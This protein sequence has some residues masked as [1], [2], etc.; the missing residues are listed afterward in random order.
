[1]N[2]YLNMETLRGTPRSH[3][4]G[5]GSAVSSAW[6]LRKKPFQDEQPH[7]LL[8]RDPEVLG[9]K[10]TWIGN[11]KASFWPCPEQC[12]PWGWA[13]ETLRGASGCDN[14]GAVTI[15]DQKNGWGLENVMQYGR[16]FF[17]NEKF[18]HVGL[19]KGRIQEAGSGG[20]GEGRLIQEHLGGCEGM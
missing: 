4:R 15:K 1:M 9:L 16:V 7:P 2:M 14:I 11:R 12:H 5:E 19:P 13:Q 8:P 18:L 3:R 10:R 20:L 6:D 17:S